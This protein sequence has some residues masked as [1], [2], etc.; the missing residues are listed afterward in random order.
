MS[1]KEDLPPITPMEVP[2]IT[3]IITCEKCGT[4]TKV[5]FELDI[6]PLIPIVA[7]GLAAAVKPEE[8]VKDIQ[9]EETAELEIKDK[10]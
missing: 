8:S 6:A 2:S 7:G 1:K 4:K 10:I 3:K 9:E 5:E